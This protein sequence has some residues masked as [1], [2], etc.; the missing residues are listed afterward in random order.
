MNTD[1]SAIRR[2]FVKK[3]CV[4]LSIIALWTLASVA[5][6][7]KSML[8]SEQYNQSSEY[9]NSPAKIIDHGDVA[10]MLIATILGLMVSPFLSYFHGIFFLLFSRVS[11][12]YCIYISIF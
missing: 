4:V 2:T 8:P 10:W 6:A 9:L 7:L 12:K 3:I 11:T 5:A 1:E